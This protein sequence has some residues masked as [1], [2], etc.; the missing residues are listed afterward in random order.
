[1]VSLLACF[2]KLNL[3]N[4]GSSPDPEAYPKATAARTADNAQQIIGWKTFLIEDGNLE[5]EKD[6]TTITVVNSEERRG[7]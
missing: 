2:I 1:M 4:T 6:K 3:P 7:N 5:K